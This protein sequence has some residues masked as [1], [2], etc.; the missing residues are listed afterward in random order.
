MMARPYWVALGFVALL[1]VVVFGWI[2][3]VGHE[4][5]SFDIAPFTPKA[6]LLH[7]DPAY[8]CA[9]LLDL[10]AA[11]PNGQDVATAVNSAPPKAAH[12]ATLE[13]YD[14]LTHGRPTPGELRAV[15]GAYTCPTS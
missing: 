3:Y 4:A 1:P 10:N 9:G 5:G 12:E 6:P 13:F 15:I 7:P 11:L 14:D 2:A 8:N